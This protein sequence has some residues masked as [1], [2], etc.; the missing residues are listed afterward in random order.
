MECYF[1][2]FFT[3]FFLKITYYFFFLFFLFSLLSWYFTYVYVLK[4]RIHDPSE[5]IIDEFLGQLISLTPILFVNGFKLDKINF[6]ELML[7][8]FLL[9]RFFDIL[10]PWPIYIVDK[11]RTSL[12]IL[13]D[14]VIA[15]L[16][17]ST[18]IIIY[19]LWI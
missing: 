2:I 8:S 18:I 5:I 9:F 15:G 14:D 16:F 3:I 7:L 1:F 19:L 4:N 11:S 6:C 12:S 17:S 10:K 13:L